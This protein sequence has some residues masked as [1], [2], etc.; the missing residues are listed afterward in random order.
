VMDSAG[1]A[2]FRKEAKPSIRAALRNRAEY[3]GASELPKKWNST[4]S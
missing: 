4:V 3:G 2:N 1:V